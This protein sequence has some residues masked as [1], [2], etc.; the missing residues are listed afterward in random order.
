MS[1]YRTFLDDIQKRCQK[2]NFKISGSFGVYD[3]YRKI[4]KHQWYDI[5]RPV[6]EHEFYSIIRSVN[7]LLGEELLKGNIVKFPYKMGN[8]ELRKTRR[9]VFMQN[10]KLR[11]TYPVNWKETLKLWYEDEEAREKKILIREESNE[12][13]HVKYCRFGA[14]YT[15][16]YFYEF[17]LNR[18]IKKALKGKID[19]GLDTL[20]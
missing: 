11:V 6:K 14:N 3:A 13:Y 10:G 4:R 20:W 17:A 16:K 5:G 1:D 12:V 15:N 8:L 19:K 2:K 18:F 7:K 9:G